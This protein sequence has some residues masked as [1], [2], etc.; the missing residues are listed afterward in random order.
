MHGPQQNCPL[1]EQVGHD[2]GLQR[3]LERVGRAQSDRP[4]Q[5]DVRRT[6]VEVLLDGEARVDP[7]AIHLPALLVQ[8]PHR[9]THAL[10]ADCDHVDPGGESL[11]YRLEET[12]QEPVR[13]PQ[14]G[15]RPERGKHLPMQV[16]LSGV[17]DQQHRE[18]RP[19]DDAEHLAQ[20]PVR[21]GES[22]RSRFSER[23]GPLPQPDRDLDVSARQRFAQVLRLRRPLRAPADDPDLLHA[24]ECARQQL[25]QVAAAAQKALAHAIEL[26]R[27]HV[28]NLRLEQVGL[29]H[30]RR[31]RPH[32]AAG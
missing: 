13:Q 14:G 7:G 2:L 9:R 31:G 4:P 3:R 25:E 12:E 22:G 30:R 20:R 1:T 6:T 26:D 28:E 17:R 18:V 27:L 19:P 29:A 8:P 24:T 10:R 5:G 32:S 11:T 15:A 21:L 23:L 16:C